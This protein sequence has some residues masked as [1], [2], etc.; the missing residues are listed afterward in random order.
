MLRSKTGNDYCEY[1]ME[2]FHRNWLLLFWGNKRHEK[3]RRRMDKS[4]FPQ[5]NQWSTYILSAHSSL[6]KQQFTSSR[7]HQHRI[8]EVDHQ[9]IDFLSPNKMSW[10]FHSSSSSSS[11]QTL[12]TWFYR[13]WLCPTIIR[14][15][16]SSTMSW[17]RRPATLHDFR[18]HTKSESSSFLSLTRC[19]V[20]CSSNHHQSIST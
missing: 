5:L 3:A 9:S 15:S 16:H 1:I 8:I 12:S 13:C 17:F 10:N 6:G 18:I 11:S 4:W 2:N 7:S 19:S 14:L 20:L